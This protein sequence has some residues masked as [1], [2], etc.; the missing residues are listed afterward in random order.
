L[1]AVENEKARIFYLD[2]L[3]G[4]LDGTT[5]I[6]ALMLEPYATDPGVI[7]AS[8]CELCPA[9]AYYRRTIVP[10]P[11][12]SD[13]AIL[14]F[15]RGRL[16]ERILADELPSV[17]KDGISGRVDGLWEGNLI[18][19]KSTAMDMDKFNP[20]TSQPHWLQRSKAYCYL[21]DQEKLTLVVWFI[22]GN[23]WTHRTLNTG[24]KCWDLE[25]TQ[26]EILQN[27]E[28]MK[29]ERAM[30]MACLEDAFVPPHGWIAARLQKYEC[31]DCSFREVCTYPKKGEKK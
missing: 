4:I 3:R 24:L 2:K 29:S 27:W 8:E 25:F 10:A 15:M 21:H 19:T 20:A 11:P 12:L 9:R 1:N 7:H 17:T 18:E 22:V 28:K 31:G 26:G 30:L 14:T 13:R 5:G 6:P 16:F 23:M